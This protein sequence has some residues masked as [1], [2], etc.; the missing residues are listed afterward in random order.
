MT[1][2]SSLSPEAQEA[3]LKIFIEDDEE[4]LFREKTNDVFILIG[5][6]G[7][8]HGEKKILGIYPTAEQCQQRADECRKSIPTFFRKYLVAKMSVGTNGGDCDFGF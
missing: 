4:E 6:L 3:F 8:K 7:M 1:R 5:K 2:L